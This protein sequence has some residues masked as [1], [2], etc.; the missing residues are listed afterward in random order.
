MCRIYGLFLSIK[1]V[2][3]NPKAIA[4]IIA[5]VA[6]AI[7]ISVGGNS[8]TGYGDAVACGG[9]TTHAVSADDP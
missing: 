9:W 4:T 1:I 2:I 8:V 5:A 6:A 3:A 7:Y